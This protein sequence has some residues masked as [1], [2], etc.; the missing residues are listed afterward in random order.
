[1]GMLEQL[2]LFQF[3]E[4]ISAGSLYEHMMDIIKLRNYGQSIVTNALVTELHQLVYLARG[5]PDRQIIPKDRLSR[6]EFIHVITYLVAKLTIEDVSAK[7]FATG[8]FKILPKDATANIWQDGI[9]F[10]L[11]QTGSKESTGGV[12]GSIGVKDDPVGGV[13]GG[14]ER[15]LGAEAGDSVGHVAAD[16]ALAGGAEAVVVT[17]GQGDGAAQCD[18]SGEAERLGVVGDGGSRAGTAGRT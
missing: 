10:V 4:N 16:G 9:N 8:F 3:K 13:G 7:K 6:L 12:E 11:K 15:S 1:M 14:G 2:G 18:Q 17:G 5:R